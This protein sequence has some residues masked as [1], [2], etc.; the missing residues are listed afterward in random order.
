MTIQG[1]H[2][3][4]VNLPWS[5]GLLFAALLAITAFRYQADLLFP[6]YRSDEAIHATA[7]DLA[8]QGRSPYD[9][10]TYLGTPFF[11]T[12]CGAVARHAGLRPTIILLRVL[13]LLAVAGIAWIASGSAALRLGWRLSLAIFLA[14]SAPPFLDAIGP[15]NLSPLAHVLTLIGI[16]HWRDRPIRGGMVLGLG[17][18]IKPYALLLVPIFFCA[19]LSRPTPSRYIFPATATA[20]FGASLLAFPSATLRMLEQHEGFAVSLRSLSIQRVLVNLVGWGPSALTVLLAVGACAI[21]ISRRHPR[22]DGELVIFALFA[23]ALGTTRIWVHVLAPLL[24]NF[25]EGFA[26]RLRVLATSWKENHHRRNEAGLAV[27]KLAVP[28]V[29]LFTSDT[30]AALE[31]PFPGLPSWAAGLGVLLPLAC[32]I[33]LPRLLL[34]EPSPREKLEGGSW[35]C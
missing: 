23:C 4:R 9:H 28:T 2:A 32:L 19:R 18:A 12:A 22:S 35:N 3:F 16:L 13:N 5:A 34:P 27:L 8:R 33:L 7:I 14:A 15:G 10:P 1:R 29:F 20:V 26:G 24:P 6:S 31:L 30:W 21:L 17:L 11:A 25:V